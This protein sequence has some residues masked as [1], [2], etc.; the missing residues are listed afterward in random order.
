[1]TSARTEQAAAKRSWRPGQLARN[2][3]LATGWQGLR[4]AFQFAYL[5][6]VA[7]L[8]GAAGYGTFSGIVALAA[9]LSPLAGAGFGLI[10]VKQVSRHPESFPRYWGKALSAI[11][12]SAPLL[13]LAMG[14]MAAVILPDTGET[15]ALLIV[16]VSEL[17]LVPLVAACANAYQAHERLGASIF[18]FVLLNGGRLLAMGALTLHNRHPNLN[19]FALAYLAGTALPAALSLAIATRTFGRPVAELRGLAGGLWEG[20]GFAASG[21][22]GVAQAEI[23]KSLL[24]RLDSAIATGTYSVATRIVFAACTPLISYMLAAVPRLFRAGTNG[25]VGIRRT[26]GILLV[27]VLVYGVLAG[28]AIYLLAPWLP[29]VLGEGFASSVSVIRMLAPLPCLIGVS[30]L[31]LAVLSCSGAQAARIGIELA[32]LGLG[33]GLNIALIPALGVSGT[34]Y[35]ALASQSALAAMTT[36]FLFIPRLAQ[37]KRVERP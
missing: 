22:T 9:T 3:V 32:A 12:I 19:L 1:M 14:A 6:V 34:V 33:I 7:R 18:N 30:S 10:L 2:T 16:G 31:L 27:P 4:L 26:A 29:A 21:V 11:T 35:A 24:L 15:L 5:I 25:I 23:D 17:L 20:L 13:I 37:E 36:L 28:G 8:L